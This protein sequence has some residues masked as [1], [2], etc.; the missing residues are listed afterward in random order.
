MINLARAGSD[1]SSG[2]PSVSFPEP[3][4][5]SSYSRK[6]RFQKAAAQF[7]LLIRNGCFDFGIVGLANADFNLRILGEISTPPL[8]RVFTRNPSRLPAADRREWA[9]PTVAVRFFLFG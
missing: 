6:I 8:P 4:A 1:L 5:I 9:K 7:T 3:R 2:V